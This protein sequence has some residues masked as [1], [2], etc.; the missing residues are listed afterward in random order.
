M[1]TFAKATKAHLG[2]VMQCRSPAME[3]LK[4]MFEV[5]LEDTKSSL[6]RAIDTVHIHRLQGRA[7]TLKDFLVLLET[8]PQIAERLK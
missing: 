4:Q 3:P 1:T 5:A 8:A 2:S 6:V 7:E